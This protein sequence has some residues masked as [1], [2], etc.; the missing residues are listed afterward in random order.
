M[1]LETISYDASHKRIVNLGFKPVLVKIWLMKII[2]CM[3]LL[4]SMQINL[5][6]YMLK[7]KSK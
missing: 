4:Y 3:L 1:G 2:F 7:I 5:F 6:N